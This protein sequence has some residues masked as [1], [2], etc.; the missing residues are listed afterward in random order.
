M[1]VEAYRFIL[2]AYS[3]SV[4][5]VKSTNFDDSKVVILIWKTRNVQVNQKVRRCRIA[6]IVGWKFSS[7]ALQELTEVL[8]IGKST[9]SDRLGPR[10]RNG[11]N[12]KRR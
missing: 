11:K 3:E 7:N 6:D 9:V 8:N 4:P 1:T 10:P 12:S 5:S 2:K